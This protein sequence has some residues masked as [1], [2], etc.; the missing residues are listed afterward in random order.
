MGENVVQGAVNPDEWYVFKPTLKQGFK[1]I[2]MKKTGAKAIKMIYT[3]DR[4]TSYNVCYTKLL[5][6]CRSP[7]CPR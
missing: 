7:R 6:H 1:P 2:I 3:T 5:R 4:I